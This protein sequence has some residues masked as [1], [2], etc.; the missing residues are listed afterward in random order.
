[1]EM[2]R[3]TAAASLYKTSRSYR[4]AG[5]LGSTIAGRVLLAKGCGPC[6]AD[7]TPPDS[8]AFTG[9]TKSCCDPF[10]ENCVRQSC[11]PPPRPTPPPTSGPTEAQCYAT[12]SF[13]MGGALGL[14]PPFDVIVAE[15]CKSNLRDCLN[16]V[17]DPPLPTSVR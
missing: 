15:V 3:F 5:T 4:R 7:P 12:F 9:F 8:G 6:I 13:C 2:P 1:M 14:L 16:S 10:G 17:P 11:P